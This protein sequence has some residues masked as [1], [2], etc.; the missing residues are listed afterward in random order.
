MSRPCVAL[1]VADQDVGL[2]LAGGDDDGVAAA[3]RA[4]QGVQRQ[5]VGEADLPGFEHG[6][7]PAV[8]F[9][10]GALAG[11]QAK[12]RG[13]R[14]GPGGAAWAAVVAASRRGLARWAR[15]SAA[16]AL[17]SRSR[18]LVSLSR[19]RLSS[20]VRGLL[21]ERRA[22]AMRK[23]SRELWSWLRSQPSLRRQPSRV[24]DWGRGV[25]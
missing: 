20:G 10:E 6:A 12:F 4:E 25:R 5:D 16:A 3:D 11:V 14:L 17:S 24:G 21:A 1:G 7:K 23:L 9:Q 22:M 15:C 2:V 13:Q 19:A 8:I 18:L